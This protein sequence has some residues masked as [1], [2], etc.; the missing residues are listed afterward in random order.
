MAAAAAATAGLS[1]RVVAARGICKRVVAARGI[2][3]IL[4][5]RAVKCGDCVTSIF[6]VATVGCVGP[7][8]GPWG[9]HQHRG[10]ACTTGVTPVLMHASRDLTGLP[11]TTGS[12]VF[13]LLISPPFNPC[14]NQQSN[15]A[16]A[17]RLHQYGMQTC[18][19]CPAPCS[20]FL[21]HPHSSRLLLR[22]CAGQHH[23]TAAAA[24]KVAISNSR[25]LTL[26]FFAH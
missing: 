24:A 15:E 7:C 9:P 16:R 4:Q 2:C 1:E 22:M 17:A 26:C 25:P 10:P 18:R 23:R 14:P 6:P 21:P 3:T 5:R 8:F 20:L 12:T 13:A 11:G 19:R